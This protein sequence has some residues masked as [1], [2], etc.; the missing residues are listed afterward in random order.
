L[1]AKKPMALP[2]IK[3][4]NALSMAIACLLVLTK[5]TSER[6]NTKSQQLVHN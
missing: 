1:N 2:P 6:N 3:H 5:N 4:I